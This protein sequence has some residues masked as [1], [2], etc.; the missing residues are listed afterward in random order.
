LP[1]EDGIEI[2]F[3]QAIAGSAAAKY[4]HGDYWLIPARVATGNIE[5]PQ[6]TDSKGEKS[7]ASLPPHGVEH[8]YAPLAVLTPGAGANKLAPFDLRRVFQPV[9]KI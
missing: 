3:P 2:Q 9:P 6:V 4:R 8:H 5:W 1:L 7:P